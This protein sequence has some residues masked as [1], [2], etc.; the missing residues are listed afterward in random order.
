MLNFE[1]LQNPVGGKGIKIPEMSKSSNWK[2]KH[3][4][5]LNNSFKNNVSCYNRWEIVS[6]WPNLEELKQEQNV[7]HWQLYHLC[8]QTCVH[9]TSWLKLK[10]HAMN[11]NVYLAPKH[12]KLCHS[13]SLWRSQ[14]W[15]KC[16][17]APNTTSHV[18]SETT[19][20]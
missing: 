9:V 2:K 19:R 16:H 18:K 14:M 17:L 20:I 15:D 7:G 4:W 3:S 11:S 1:I 13:W 10:Q 6:I 12:Y 5:F 8:T